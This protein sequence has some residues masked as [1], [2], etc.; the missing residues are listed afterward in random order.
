MDTRIKL[1]GVCTNPV[2]A[3]PN[4]SHC[5]SLIWMVQYPLRSVAP[6]RLPRSKVYLMTC[7]WHHQA[8]ATFSPGRDH[9]LLSSLSSILF[10]Q[11]LTAMCLSA[12]AQYADSFPS[13]SPAPSPSQKR[14]FLSH[15]IYKGK[16]AMGVVPMKPTFFNKVCFPH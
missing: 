3:H 4:F 6:I 11:P 5:T 9:H 8:P 14:V 2:R 7:I 13:Q 15:T 12:A 16:A 1:P 10:K